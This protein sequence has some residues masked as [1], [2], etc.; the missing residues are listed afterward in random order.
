M[1]PKRRQTVLYERSL[2]MTLSSPNST[3]VPRPLLGKRALVTGATGGL[4]GAIAQALGRDGADVLVS[5]RDADRGASTVAAVEE[6]GGRGEFVAAD[7]S[8]PPRLGELAQEVG[9]IEI[10]VNNAGFAV[11]GATPDLG[12]DEFDRMF[13]A[14]VRA[15]YYLVAAFAPGMSARGHGSIINIGSMAG[16]V[17]LVGGAAYGA[18]KA[19]LGALTRA[20]A[21][22]YSPTGVRVNNVAPG[23]IY[24]R[25]EDRERFATI[26]DTTALGRA[27]APDEIAE[28]VA[29]LASPRASYITGATF[30][31]DG[32]RT[33]I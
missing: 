29:F 5:G 1:V 25:P 26:G 31:A 18:T 8:D 9:D 2:M 3:S 16:T 13:A 20:W 33:A 4:G 27:A 10:L 12:V 11:W 30:A 19:A 24:T 17:G 6:A 21:A 22:E 7:L 14:N 15:P 32:G 28:L 23:P